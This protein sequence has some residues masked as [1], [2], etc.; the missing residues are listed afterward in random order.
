VVSEEKMDEIDRSFNIPLENPSDALYRK[1]LLKVS[2]F[3]F[4][5]VTEKE[6]QYVNIFDWCKECVH[7]R[8][9]FGHLL[10]S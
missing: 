6:H 9:N 8:N 10:L 3:M 2:G 5:V 1:T 4:Q 7:N